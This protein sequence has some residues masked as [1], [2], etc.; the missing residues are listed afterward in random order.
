MEISDLLK[1][2][3]EKK[4]SDLHLTAGRPPVLRIDGQL[5]SM[6]LPTLTPGETR[7]LVYS[8]LSDLQ[9][10]KFEE[11]KELDFSLGVA[12]ISRYRVNV[13]MQ[14][15]SIAAAFRT[16]PSVIPNFEDL[17]LP[18]KV[19]EQVSL[20]PTGLVL[21]T[22]PTGHG[23]S[24]TLA[25]M[26]D[27]INK[28]RQCHIICIEDPIEYLHSH[29]KSVV[30]QR[31]VSEDTHSF[32]NALKY[33]LRQD[34]DVIMIGEMRDIETI[35]AALTAAETGHLVL[36]TLHT[37]DVMQ[38][39]N[40]V[41]DVFPP[42]QQSQV[43]VQMAASL[44]GVFCQRLLPLLYGNGRVLGLE[45][46]LATDAVRNIVREGKSEQLQ[47]AIESGSKLGMITMDKCLA[48]LFK[49]GR[50]SREVALANAKKPEEVRRH[51]NA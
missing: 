27:L 30:E 37:N 34:P 6:E 20:R 24:T 13:H 12:K 2:S 25:A 11:A 36:S 15:G 39:V 49:R 5:E 7:R 45:I 1:A 50:I 51:M 10:Q 4:A 40:R 48:D 38:T 26:I 9:K 33:V 8:V 17:H 47:T 14:R 23:K 46:M 16:I 29:Q 35:A 22:G 28:K 19:L 44:E 31:E 18:V 3:V 32:G 42:H 43:K 41:I 21:V